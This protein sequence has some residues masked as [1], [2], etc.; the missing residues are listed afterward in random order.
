MQAFELHCRADQPG[1]TRSAESI[2]TAAMPLAITHS[3]QHFYGPLNNLLLG[4]PE[5]VLSAFVPE[6]NVS[7]IVR[8]NNRVARGL[9]NRTKAELG[10]TKFNLLPLQFAKSL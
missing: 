1:L 3:H 2:Q 5:H 10:R 9:D 8:Q 4:I 6:H 7:T